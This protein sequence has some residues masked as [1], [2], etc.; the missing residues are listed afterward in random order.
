MAPV[1]T[2]KA[3]KGYDAIAMDP[4]GR[5]DGLYRPLF[6]HGRCVTLK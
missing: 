3:N 5:N 6:E 4:D 1:D 2:S